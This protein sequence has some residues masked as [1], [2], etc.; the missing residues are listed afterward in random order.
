MG[1]KI[2]FTSLLGFFKEL[3]GNLGFEKVGNLP[4]KFILFCNLFQNK[5]IKKYDS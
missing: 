2:R 3:K 5:E 4:D 1:V